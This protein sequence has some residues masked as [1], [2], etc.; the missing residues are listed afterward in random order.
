M[1]LLPVTKEKIETFYVP[2][3]RSWCFT[4]V[5]TTEKNACQEWLFEKQMVLQEPIYPDAV[6]ARHML[7]AQAKNTRVT[8]MVSSLQKQLAVI[9]GKLLLTPSDLNLLKSQMK[10]DNKLELAKFKLTDVVEVKT[11]AAESMVFNS[12]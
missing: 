8:K 2:T 6:L 9:E 7:C 4:L 11:T 1:P 10:V 3:R 12:A 5:P